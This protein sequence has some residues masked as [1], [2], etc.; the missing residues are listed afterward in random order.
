VLNKHPFGCEAVTTSP[1][2][3]AVTLT[4]NPLTHKEII[5]LR[6]SNKDF[7]KSL[8][9]VCQNDPV[10]NSTLEKYHTL[11][12]LVKKTKR[13]LKKVHSVHEAIY[14]DSLMV[15]ICDFIKSKF[16][17]NECFLL[18]AMFTSNQKIANCLKDELPDDCSLWHLLFEKLV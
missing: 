5:M 9:S 13:N 6:I 10:L 2:R 3:Q 7:F 1:A 18:L 15:L 11:K 16:S 14:E 17:L 8:K 12:K 4:I